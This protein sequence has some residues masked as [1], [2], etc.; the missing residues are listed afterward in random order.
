MFKIVPV[1]G[2]S[3][4]WVTLLCLCLVLLDVGC[5]ESMIR[6]ARGELFHSRDCMKNAQPLF[7][8]DSLD[9]RVTQIGDNT[10]TQR[11]THRQANEEVYWPVFV[12]GPV[13]LFL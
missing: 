4:L 11:L 6:Y 10:S 8:V 7:T 2:D 13:C 1:N 12:Y 3:V 5:T 9:L